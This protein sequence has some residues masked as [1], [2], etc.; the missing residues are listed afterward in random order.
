MKLTKKCYN[1][2]V[3]LSTSSK[4]KE[5]IP[6]RCFSDV[7]EAEFKTNRITV[8]CCDSCNNLYSKFDN[9]LRDMVSILKDGQ[10]GNVSFLQKGIKSV[11]K[12]KELGSEIIL[13]N[14]QEG[15]KIRLSYN[16]IEQQFLKC[17]KGV[18]YHLFGF[19]IDFHFDSFVNQKLIN[20]KHEGEDFEFFAR[21]H[22]SKQDSYIASG[23]P[24]IFQIS[25]LA[26]KPLVIS[27]SVELTTDIEQAFIV[28][29]HMVFHGIVDAIVYSTRKDSPLFNFKKK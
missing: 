21:I 28:T 27:N 11:L 29:S 10:D 9:E 12:N 8:P 2:G 7:Y 3:E 20:S 16:S 23:H 6:P 24:E 17:H 25:M 4:T 1:C 13:S 15:H 18:F 19:P 26:F 14:G 5:H 22:Y